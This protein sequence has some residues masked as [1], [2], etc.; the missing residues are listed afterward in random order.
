MGE[1]FCSYFVMVVGSSN[2]RP[3]QTSQVM[4]LYLRKE[5]RLVGPFVL[6]GP[7][8]LE[9]CRRSQNLEILETPT[10]DLETD[11]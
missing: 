9:G 7:C 3:E 10:Y 2:S 6:P 5:K 1:F 4:T 8:F 11:R